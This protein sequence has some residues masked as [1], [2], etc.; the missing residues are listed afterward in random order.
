MYDRLTIDDFI[1]LVGQR[2]DVASLIE[3]DSL[4]LTGT[5]ASRAVPNDGRRKGFSLFFA[6]ANRRYY[7]P[8]GCYDLSHP[9]LALPGL[10][11]VPLGPGPDG[12]MRYEA[13]FS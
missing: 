12:A 13:D 4:T 3:P 9:V 1:P 5:L 7:L 11:I 6:G 2:F 8:Q 10:F